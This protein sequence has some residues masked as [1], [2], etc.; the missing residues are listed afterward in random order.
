MAN[1]RLELDIDSDVYPELYAKLLTI[2]TPG[3]RSERV[4]QL[5][6]SGLVW[7]M[8]RIEGHAPPIARR[9]AGTQPS[10]RPAVP[11]FVD[12]AIDAP[13]PAA[14]A[15][16]ARLPVLTDVLEPMAVTPAREGAE[17]SDDP[18]LPETR[19]TQPLWPHGSKR[20]PS[21]RSR[22]MRMKERGLFKNG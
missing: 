8:L 21:T 14:D 16:Q 18:P 6:A 5:A 2:V 13:A 22:L 9:P 11:G 17:E 15:A 3:G 1:L 19:H 12:L 4:R 10:A 7:E 20:P